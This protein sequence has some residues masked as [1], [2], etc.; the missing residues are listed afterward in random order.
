MSKLDKRT[1]NALIVLAVGMGLAIVA[2]ETGLLASLRDPSFVLLGE[3]SSKR[4]ASITKVRIRV[5]GMLGGRSDAR[6]EGYGDQTPMELAS[7]IQSVG[8]LKEA[9]RYSSPEHVRAVFE[10]ACLADRPAVVEALRAVD[11]GLSCPPAVGGQ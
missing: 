5:A 2:S 1:R 4:G 10:H 6:V 9:A 3:T 11:T 8:F 7:E